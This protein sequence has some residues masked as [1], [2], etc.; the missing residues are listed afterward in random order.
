MEILKGK[1]FILWVDINE[2]SFK[3]E[4]ECESNDALH[5]ILS[6]PDAEYILRPI[7]YHLFLSIQITNNTL[8]RE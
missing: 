2:D 8:F 6:L 5:L 1:D 3:S 4:D 7:I